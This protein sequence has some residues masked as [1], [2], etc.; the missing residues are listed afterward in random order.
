MSTRAFSLSLTVLA[1]VATVGWSAAETRSRPR[2]ARAKRARLDFEKSV[3]RA[4]IAYVKELDVALRQAA[5]NKDK[6]E[7]TRIQIEKRDV[8]TEVGLIDDPIAKTRKRLEGTRWTFKRGRETRKLSLLPGSVLREDKM[9]N[10]AWAMLDEYSAVL[11]PAAAL[12]VIT[13]DKS[14]TKFKV[15]A[16]F[17]PVGTSYTH[18]ERF[19]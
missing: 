10:G 8:I 7:I 18:G 9:P 12:F 19:E 14:L 3:S 15:E 13:F 11:K 17:N 5:G 6:D 2:S 1:V 16:A 4:R